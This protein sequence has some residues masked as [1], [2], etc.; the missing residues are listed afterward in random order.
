MKVHFLESLITTS[1]FSSKAELNPAP[2]F[3]FSKN[4]KFFFLQH[5]CNHKE[6]ITRL[7]QTYLDFY[8]YTLIT[9][10][11]FT[12]K[13]ILRNKNITISKRSHCS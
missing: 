4:F 3:E 2:F 13:N 8:L 10:F 1:F 5:R 12:I 6:A 7:H 11:S 9:E